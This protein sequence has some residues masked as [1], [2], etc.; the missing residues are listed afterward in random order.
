MFDV[1][2]TP[3]NNFVMNSDAQNPNLDTAKR[4]AALANLFM[5]LTN[6]GGFNSFLTSTYDF[7][8]HDFFLA[9]QRTGANIAADHL[10]RVLDGL[11]VPLLVS[12][13][14]ERWDVLELYWTDDLDELDTLSREADLQLTTLL[15][16][17][18][19]NNQEYYLG[20][21]ADWS[22]LEGKAQ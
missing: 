3:W 13:Q 2:I 1:E 9:L 7:D 14:S 10:R 6:N 15:T 12:S 22:F 11:G 16:E 21:T 8:A 19:E 5:N 20:L 4:D 17:H 18:V